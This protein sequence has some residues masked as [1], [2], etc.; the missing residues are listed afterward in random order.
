MAGVIKFTFKK[1]GK[2]CLPNIEGDLSV[3]GL[4]APVEVLRDKW[5]VPHIYAENFHDLFFAQGFVHAQDRLWQMELHRRVASGTLAEIF[6]EAALDT[7]R[8]TRTFGFRRIGIAHF[9]KLGAE[10]QLALTAHA[11]GVN[12]WLNHPNFVVPL[13]FTLI[14]H[15]PTPWTVD[16]SLAFGQF[17]AWQLTGQF[18]PKIARTQILKLIGQ[19]RFEQ[20]L[21]NYLPTNPAVIPSKMEFN[22]FQPDGTLKDIPG[23]FVQ[24]GGGSNGWAITGAKSTTGKPIHCTD[25]HLAPSTPAIWYMMHLVCGD[26]QVYG[27]GPAS[28]PMILIGHNARISWGFT[29]SNVDAEDLFIEKMNP[30]NPTQ[31]QYKG[32][33]LDAEVI[34]ETIKVKDR[35]TPHIEQV[36]ITKHGPIVNEA[37]GMKAD[38][39]EERIALCS[40]SLEPLTTFQGVWKLNNAKNWDDFAAA[41]R[42][43]SAPHQNMTFADVEGNIGSYISGRIPIRKSGDGFTAVPG[44][45]GDHDWTGYIPFE[46]VPHQLNPKRG[47]VVTANNCPIKDK[48]YKYYLSRTFDPGYRARR[49]SEFIES[50]PT[51]GPEDFKTLQMDFKATHALQFVERLKSFT[52]KDPDVELALKLLREWDGILSA[53]TIGGTIYE[54]AIDS[55]LEILLSF[56]LS[57]SLVNAYLGEGFHPMLKATTESYH[58]SVLILL[59]LLDTPDA[60][61]IQQVGGRDALITQGLKRTIEYLRTELGKNPEKW[62]WGNLNKIVYPHA[63]SI[64]KPL[65]KVFNIGPEPIGGDKLTVCQQGPPFNTKSEKIWTPSYRHIVNLADLDSSWVVFA[66]GQSGHLASPHYDDLFKLWYRGDYLPMLWSRPK[67]EQNLEAKLILKSK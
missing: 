20:I 39:K 41:V 46:D 2:K 25:P 50:K 24:R 3:P 62:Q 7:D 61:W 32:K 45:T 44:W 31:Y 52:T 27:V 48:D 34:S 8:A 13:E 53:T 42:D 49:I 28:L 5:G 10:A 65:D 33:W 35:A 16:D 40:V 23:P 54:I 38:S 58:P 4:Q 14:K 57:K 29:V 66:P 63:M 18:T 19:E 26:Y 9:E 60:W 56:R 1:M 36:L 51:L 22:I 12:A 30:Q 37:I 59:N 21:P 11:E 67:V 64:Q 6:G 17:M 47:Y 15:T 55:M 43:I